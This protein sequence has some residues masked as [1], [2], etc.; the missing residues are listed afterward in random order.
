MALHYGECE[1]SRH[2]LLR[3]IV[4][5][6]QILAQQGGQIRQSGRK[7]HHTHDEPYGIRKDI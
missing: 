5:Y 6:L 1:G 2:L 4:Q 3:Y 7:E